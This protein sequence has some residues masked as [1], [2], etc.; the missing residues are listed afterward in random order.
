MNT[1]YHT[2]TT[3]LPGHKIE[4]STPELPEGQQVQV[5][6]ISTAASLP[7]RKTGPSALD[8]I[9]SLKGHRLFQTPEEVDRYI[10]EERNSW[11][12]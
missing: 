3:V 9:E 11:D 8:I 1:A 4:I 2:T 5:V 12:R 7:T 10:D 6:V